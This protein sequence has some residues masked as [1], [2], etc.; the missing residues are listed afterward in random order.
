MLD[1]LAKLA[2]VLGFFISLVTFFLTRWER[3][4]ALDFGLQPG[5]SSDFDSDSDESLETVNLAITNLGHQP[6]LLNM[7]TLEIRCNGNVLH[8]WRE[9]YFGNQ[10]QEVLLKPT[11]RN[12][13]G[14]PLVTFLKGLKIESPE[15]YDERSF[16]A[17]KPVRVRLKT[18]EGRQFESKKLRFWEAVGEF[19]RA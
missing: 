11:E 16:F 17:L 8:A 19:H 10:Q 18:I 13:V 4:A 9:D 14:I 2:G 7:P 3:R 5:H 15:K 12:V 6:T 1:D